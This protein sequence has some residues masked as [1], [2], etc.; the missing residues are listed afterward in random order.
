MFSW[1]SSED[2]IKNERQREEREEFEKK[3]EEEEDQEI[4]FVISHRTF[5]QAKPS[6]QRY[7]R[8]TKYVTLTRACVCVCERGTE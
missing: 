8:E 5:G 4:G 1:S 7:Q 2:L 3:E 6:H